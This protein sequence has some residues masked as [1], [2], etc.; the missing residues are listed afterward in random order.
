[1]SG[2][3]RRTSAIKRRGSRREI[4]LFL[5]FR[6]P[7]TCRSLGDCLT[8][9]RSQFTGSGLPSQVSQMNCVRILFSWFGHLG[10][11]LSRGYKKIKL[12]SLTLLTA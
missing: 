11:T 9:L 8:L 4:G 2:Q 6:P 3:M 12:F 5:V 10:W 1:M 7:R